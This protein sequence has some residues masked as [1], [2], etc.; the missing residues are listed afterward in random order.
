LS[1]RDREFREFFD[2]EFRPLRRLAYLLVGDWGEA[3]DLAQEAMVRTYRAWARITEKE[4]PA[5]YARTVLV[6][7]HRSLLRRAKVEAKH[8]VARQPD[9]PPVIE[10][11]GDDQVVVWQALQ[12][13][14]PRERQALVLRYYEDLP[15]AEIA[16]ILGIPIGTV[17]SLT[18]RALGRLREVLGP[19]V[20][21]RAEEP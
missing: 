1:N 12:T 13:L 15:Q 21:V 19:D 6:N 17:K 8:A 20:L 18:H 4:R 9:A 3:E 11:I 7:R 5:A 2:A 16:Q 14:P 10:G